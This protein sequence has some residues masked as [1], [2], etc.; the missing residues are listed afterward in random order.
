MA[1]RVD[2]LLQDTTKLQHLREN[3]RISSLKS[4]TFT[5]LLTSFPSLVNNPIM[6]GCFVTH[7]EFLLHTQVA[8]TLQTEV[9]HLRSSRHWKVVC[10]AH[11]CMQCSQGV[12]MATSGMSAGFSTAGQCCQHSTGIKLQIS[13]TRF[14]TKCFQDLCTSRIQY[15]VTLESVKQT[16]ADIAITP[17]SISVT[18]SFSL[19]SSSAERSSN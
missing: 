12:P 9:L 3:R 13:D 11:L 4:S 7:T 8:L 16:L 5:M 17:F 14:C 10:W 2:D 18:V 6:V 1:I 15:S 19:Y